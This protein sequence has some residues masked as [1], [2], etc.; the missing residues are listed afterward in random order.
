MS[1]T[2]QNSGV[3]ETYATV[4]KMWLNKFIVV[5]GEW[6]ELVKERPVDCDTAEFWRGP[7]KNNLH[8]NVDAYQDQTYAGTDP[9]IGICGIGYGKEY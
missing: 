9:E 4:V 2:L 1:G 8:I 5:V 6:I 3:D 7:E